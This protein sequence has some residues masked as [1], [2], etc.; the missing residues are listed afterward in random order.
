MHGADNTLRNPLGTAKHVIGQ[1]LGKAVNFLGKQ[2][3]G[4]DPQQDASQR[5]ASILDI[6][7]DVR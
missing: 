4:R 6:A 1:T 5:Q 2:F 7:L 3:F